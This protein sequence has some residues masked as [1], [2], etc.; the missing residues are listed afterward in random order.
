MA[1]ISTWRYLSCPYYHFLTENLAPYQHSTATTPV[2]TQKDQSL[3]LPSEVSQE[4][5]HL[6]ALCYNI[7]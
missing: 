1:P 3:T 6:L 5:L 4:G 2:E 7:P